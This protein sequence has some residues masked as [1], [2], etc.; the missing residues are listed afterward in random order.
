MAQQDNRQEHVIL[1]DVLVAF[2]QTKSYHVILLND[3]GFLYRK[4]KVGISKTELNSLRIEEGS[5][6]LLKDYAH[7]EQLE[8][9]DIVGCQ[10]M[11]DIEKLYANP[12]SPVDSPPNQNNTLSFTKAYF[13]IY[14]YV[15]RKKRNSLTKSLK[16]HRVSLIMTVD[17][18]NNFADNLSLAEKWRDT[19]RK[20][21]NGKLCKKIV[22]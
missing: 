1:E 8:F 21:L 22:D 19:I 6:V 9:N 11:K 20:L 18:S 5:K 16:R 2:G 14:A 15:L 7:Y 4:L 13:C 10:C 12:A 17:H 3:S